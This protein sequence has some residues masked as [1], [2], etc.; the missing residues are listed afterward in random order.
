M[1]RGLG[2]Q[3]TILSCDNPL[4]KNI[5]SQIAKR[6]L[7]SYTRNIGTQH[8]FLI[9]ITHINELGTSKDN[10]E[11]KNIENCGKPEQKILT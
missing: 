10:R 9:F 3:G 2:K 6:T 5:F 11:S 4:F 8:S 7:S 1:M